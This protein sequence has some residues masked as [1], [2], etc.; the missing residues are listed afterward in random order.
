MIRKLVIAVLLLVGCSSNVPKLA[1]D[2]LASRVGEEVELTG[3]FEG[4]GKIA[5]YVVVDGKM[6]YLLNPRPIVPAYGAK[7]V[8]K[9]KLQYSPAQA[10]GPEIAATLPEHYFIDSALLLVVP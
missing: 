6:I 7:I 2:T 4:P 9:G 5:D 3:Q 8:A 10:G 1:A